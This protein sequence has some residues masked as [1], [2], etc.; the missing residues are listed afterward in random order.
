MEQ[1]FQGRDVRAVAKRFKEQCCPRPTEGIRMT[2][3]LADNLKGFPTNSHLQRRLKGKASSCRQ[4]K[5][6]Y[7]PPLG[8][9]GELLLPLAEEKEGIAASPTGRHCGRHFQNFVKGQELL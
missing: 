5:D 3:F 8:H 2:N 6:A 4:L 1:C 9:E 7:R